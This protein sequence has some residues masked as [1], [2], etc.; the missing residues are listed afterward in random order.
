MSFF[1]TQRHPLRQEYEPP[2]MRI[3]SPLSSAVKCTIIAGTPNKCYAVLIMASESTSIRFQ[4]VPVNV[5][6]SIFREKTHASQSC[7][8]KNV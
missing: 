8:E 7:F 3:R 6:L 1:P 4:G 5:R 2:L